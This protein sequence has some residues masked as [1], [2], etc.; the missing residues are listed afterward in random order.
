MSLG[1]PTWLYGHEPATP[2]ATHIAK[3]FDNSIREDTILN[4]TRGGIIY[5]PG[6]AGTIQEIF[7]AAV[8]NHYLTHG[9][10]TQMVFLGED[11]W[12]REMPVYQLLEYLVEEGKYA[13]LRIS[14]TDRIDEVV[15]TIKS[16]R[17]GAK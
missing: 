9:G 5:A 4:I 10:E 7:Q 6:S 15:N 17:P 16:Y 8:P 14:I 12:R 3:F 2:F 1:I 11:F 13:G